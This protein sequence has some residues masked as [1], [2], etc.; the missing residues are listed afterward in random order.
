MK[1][2]DTVLCSAWTH[3]SYPLHIANNVDYTVTPHNGQM[4]LAR[5]CTPI[6]SVDPSIAQ[7][8]RAAGT[9]PKDPT[10]GS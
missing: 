8:R 6:S 9:A 2:F 10:S 1:N 4:A 5:G 3:R 7:Y